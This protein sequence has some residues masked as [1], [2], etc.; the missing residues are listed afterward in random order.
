MRPQANDLAAIER[1][2]QLGGSADN[3][4]LPEADID[5]DARAA[6]LTAKV[7]SALAVFEIWVKTNEDRSVAEQLRRT[8]SLLP[9]LTR[10]RCA[11]STT[12][13]RKG[14]EA[15]TVVRLDKAI[16]RLR[17]VLAKKVKNGRRLDQLV[18]HTAGPA[19]LPDDPDTLVNATLDCVTTHCEQVLLRLSPGKAKT[20]LATT[21]IDSLLVLAHSSFVID[22]RA[23]HSIALRFLQR[24]LPVVGL[25]EDRAASIDL[26]LHYA[27]RALSSALYN[28]GGIL[29]N[30]GS[31][32]TGLP[33]IQAG[34][35][36]ASAALDL[37]EARAVFSTS[38]DALDS[39]RQLSLDD[40]VPPES[41]REE[42]RQRHDAVKDLERVMARRWDLLALTQRA[43]GDKAVS[44]IGI[45]VSSSAGLTQR[46]DAGL[47]QGQHRFGSRAARLGFGGP[48]RQDVQKLSFGGRR[49]LCRPELVDQQADQV[50]DV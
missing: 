23:T 28:L 4:A 42:E 30:A 50:G 8:A 24:A 48:S 20:Q 9:T 37:D 47:V 22:D 3:A 32:A 26:D 5:A 35:D 45:S 10:L 6:H 25:F 15:Q 21:T 13:E 2:A 18:R 39:F 1:V 11:G 41:A 46:F 17:Y 7:V 29:Y 40:D 38:I 44:L 49:R 33:F 19:P 34:C 27:I 36:L 16:D 14:L 43:L 12:A 31:S